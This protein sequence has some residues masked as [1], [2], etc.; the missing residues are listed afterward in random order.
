MKQQYAHFDFELIHES[1]SGPQPIYLT[2]GSS[3]RCSSNWILYNLTAV[4]GKNNTEPGEMR[5]LFSIVRLAICCVRP[6]FALL[7]FS[8]SEE[9]HDVWGELSTSKT[10]FLKLYFIFERGGKCVP[11]GKVWLEKRDHFPSF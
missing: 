9:L 3:I 7:L 2:F 5:K 4:S 11:R 1:Q 10:Y 6:L 8:V